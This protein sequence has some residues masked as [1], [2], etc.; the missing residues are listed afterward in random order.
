MAE[1]KKKK[2]TIDEK[3]DNLKKQK[4]EARDFFNRILGALEALQTIK[5]E[6]DEKTD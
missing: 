5:D 1:A 2:L 3:I 4:E 6:N